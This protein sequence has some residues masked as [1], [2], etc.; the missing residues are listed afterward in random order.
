LAIPENGAND[1]FLVFSFWFLA[2]KAKILKGLNR[3]RAET[4]AIQYDSK[5]IYHQVPYHQHHIAI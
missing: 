3:Y 4:S 2:E 1:K 5:G